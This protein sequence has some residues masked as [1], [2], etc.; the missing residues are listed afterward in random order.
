MTSRTLLSPFDLSDADQQSGRTFRKQI[1]KKGTINYEGQK[2][3]F[4]DAFCADVV[5]SFHGGAYDQVPFVLADM[6]NRHNMDPERFRGEIVDMEVTPD[7][8]DAIVKTTKAGAKAIESNPKLGVSA[9]IVQGLDKVDGRRFK[10]AIQHVLAT[11]D[12][13]LTGMRPWQAVELSEEFDDDEVLDLT[14]ATITKGTRVGTKTA[15]R[16]PAGSRDKVL[17]LDLSNLDDGQFELLLAAVME[18]TR[19]G[20]EGDGVIE[21]TVTRKTKRPAQQRRQREVV[22][23]EDPE[24]DEDE[25]LE[26]DDEEED[27]EFV[28]SEQVP[29]EDGEE[30]DEDEL[31][32]EEAE[33]EAPVA[34]KRRRGVPKQSKRTELSTPV[35]R[36]K[37]SKARRLELQLSEERWAGKKRDLIDAG[38]PPAILDLADPIMRQPDRLVIDLSETGD[39][40]VD[41]KA[42][43]GRVLEQVSGM[44]DLAPEMGHGVSTVERDKDG[45]LTNQGLQAWSNEY[46]KP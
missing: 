29:E 32:D 27:D 23:E 5:R 46:G 43:L 30:V 45:N 16:R 31:D 7:G 44:I 42:V 26:E 22:A 41:A 12:P 24:L 9:R 11:M 35:K 28:D 33:E 8:I 3:V 37:V 15:K 39:K 4:D 2:V 20:A 6:S 13:R 10:A 1:L 25:D 14:T 40:S 17:S 34:R 19:V 36:K 38:V 21:E 18:D